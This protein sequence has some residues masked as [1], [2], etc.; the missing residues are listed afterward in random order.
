MTCDACPTLLLCGASSTTHGRVD[1]RAVAPGRPQTHD[2]KPQHP[3]PRVPSHVVRRARELLP[4][5][6]VPVQKLVVRAVR[7]E[8]A[9]VNGPVHVPHRRGVP[10][11]PKHALVRLVLPSDGV[12]IDHR[13]ARRHRELRVVRG[14]LDVLDAG[15]PRAVVEDDAEIAFVQHAELA[16][17]AADR[18]VMRAVRQRPVRPRLRAVRHGHERRERV[19]RARDRPRCEPDVRPSSDHRVRRVPPEDV[20]RAGGGDEHVRGAVVPA[21]AAQV[22]QRRG[23]FHYH[24]GVDPVDL[25]H[26]ALVRADDEDVRAGVAIDRANRGDRIRAARRRRRLELRGL[27]HDVPDRVLARVPGHHDAVRAAG[28]QR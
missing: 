7:P 5:G 17:A 11:Q 25:P 27:A 15:F 2:G 23:G 10:P 16:A 26:V 9:R 20:A 12:H 13:V 24:P 21:R 19:V 22:A 18:D 3:G 4:R 14:V 6:R 8:R 28:Q 1:V